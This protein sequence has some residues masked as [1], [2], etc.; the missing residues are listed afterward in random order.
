MAPKWEK[1]S[2]KITENGR[3]MAENGQKWPKWGEHN[4]KWP[5]MAEKWAKMVNGGQNGYY[6]W[7]FWVVVGH[8]WLFLV[9][10]RCNGVPLG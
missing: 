5:Q 10:S 7:L 2:K 9:K 6:L 8:F 3:K 1:M 4:Q